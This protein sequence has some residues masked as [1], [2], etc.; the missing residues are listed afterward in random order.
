MYVAETEAQLPNDDKVP[1]VALGRVTT[2]T[3]DNDAGDI[4]KRN[5]TN[6]GWEEINS[7]DDWQIYTAN[8]VEELPDGVA[9]TSFGRVVSGDGRGAMYVRSQFNNKWVS[10]THWSNWDEA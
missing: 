7:G 1:Q 6:D 4:F 3:G 2:T 5:G 8:S 9:A 10:F